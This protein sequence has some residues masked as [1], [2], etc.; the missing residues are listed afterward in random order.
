VAPEA[1]EKA[2]T[3]VFHP[4]QKIRPQKD[5]SLIVEFTADGLKEMAWHLMTWEG[6]IK[7]IAPKELVA[8]YK[9]QV[10]LAASALKP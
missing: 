5:G 2:S 8:E 9:N 10:K 4:T 6:M 3:F 1:A 7:P